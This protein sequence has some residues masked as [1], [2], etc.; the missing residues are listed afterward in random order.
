MKKIISYS[1]WGRDKIYLSGMVENLKLAET[2]KGWSV[3]IHIAEDC[4][5]L[6]Y[7][8]YMGAELIVM[9][10]AET[11]DKTKPGWENS[12]AHFA[13]LW[14]FLPLNDPNVE[15]MISRDSDSRLSPRCYD[16]VCEWENSGMLGHV[17]RECESHTNG[18][19]VGLIGSICNIHDDMPTLMAEFIR[20]YED[21]FPDQRWVFMDNHFARI[22]II[23]PILFSTLFHGY[24]TNNPLRIPQP[25]ECGRFV[26]DIIGESMRGQIWTSP[27]NN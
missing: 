8:E 4:P 18:L 5:A 3:R 10:P 22:H 1:L 2:Y 7:L 26:G 13:S 21:R 12:P 9:P 27:N 11:L 16:A 6:K 17:I 25:P 19:M 20:T 24:G 14:R 15:R 23:E